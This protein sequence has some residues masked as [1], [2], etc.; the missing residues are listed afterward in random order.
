[1]RSMAALGSFAGL[2]ASL[3]KSGTYLAVVSTLPMAFAMSRLT[4]LSIIIWVTNDFGGGDFPKKQFLMD[5]LRWK[6]EKPALHFPMFLIFIALMLTKFDMIVGLV[7]RAIQVSRAQKH[8]HTRHLLDLLDCAGVL[9]IWLA[10]AEYKLASAT[11]IQAC[12]EIDTMRWD[13]R[14]RTAVLACEN[15][16]LNLRRLYASLMVLN[17]VMLICPIIRHFQWEEHLKRKG[18]KSQ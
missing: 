7:Q 12:E 16:A 4:D 17:I 3:S 5:Y 9:G 18:A 2:S 10:R 11:T 1:L 8:W 13:R 14:A 6:E 15:E